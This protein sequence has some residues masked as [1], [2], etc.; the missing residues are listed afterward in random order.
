MSKKEKETVVTE[1]VVTPKK[2]K[3]VKSPN[4]VASGK[5][6]R[7]IRDGLVEKLSG[8]DVLKTIFTSTVYALEVNAGKAEL[9]SEEENILND[10]RIAWLG[11]DWGVQPKNN[12]TIA[13]IRSE[14]WENENDTLKNLSKREQLNL[15]TQLLTTQANNLTGTG[16]KKKGRGKANV[17]VLS[18][19]EILLKEVG[20]TKLPTT[21]AEAEA[22]TTKLEQLIK[23]SE[24]LEITIHR[25]KVEEAQRTETRIERLERERRGAKA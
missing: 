4:R 17:V 9:T 7:A 21:S 15:M 19:I 13:N 3:V 23:L 20:N 6:S 5:A 1:E 25:S 22:L 10:W 14:W 12:S 18:P 24:D 8:D 2:V 11:Y 16:A